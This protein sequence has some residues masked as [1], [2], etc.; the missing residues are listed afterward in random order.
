MKKYIYSLIAV[1]A[2]FTLT[3]QTTIQSI[4]YKGTVTMFSP[5]VLKPDKA[6]ALAKV[7]DF[8]DAEYFDHSDGIATIYSSSYVGGLKKDGTL[9]QIKITEVQNLQAGGKKGLGTL[10]LNVIKP[11]YLCQL[12][13]KCVIFY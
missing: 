6:T 13:Q 4:D 10:S 9:N 8:P 7:Q 11:V 12:F 1:V 3:A 2:A 5:I